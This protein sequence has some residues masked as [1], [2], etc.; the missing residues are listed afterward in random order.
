MLLTFLRRGRSY[1]GLKDV[2]IDVKLGVDADPAYKLDYA[3]SIV[4]PCKCLATFT[5]I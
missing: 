3:V 4:Y 1:Q 2:D 5:R